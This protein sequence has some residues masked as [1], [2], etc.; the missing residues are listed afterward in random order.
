[1]LNPRR[2]R[3]VCEIFSDYITHLM[4]F[5]LTRGL[6]PG[7]LCHRRRRATLKGAKNASPPLSL[8]AKVSYITCS[9]LVIQ[10]RRF[11]VIA[12]VLVLDALLYPVRQVGAFVFERLAAGELVQWVVQVQCARRDGEARQPGRPDLALPGQVEHELDP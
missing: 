1:M 11:G 7:G 5:L 6:C 12:H 4:Q 2:S 3:A 9:S 8:A 10:K